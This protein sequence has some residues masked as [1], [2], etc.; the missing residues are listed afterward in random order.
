MALV[1]VLWPRC[2][3][4]WRGVTMLVVAALQPW[5]WFVSCPVQHGIRRGLRRRLQVSQGIVL[6]VGSRPGSLF[7][8]SPRVA[9]GH[10]L[11][12][13]GWGAPPARKVS[14][15]RPLSWILSC[16]RR[17]HMCVLSVCI[18]TVGFVPVATACAVL[19]CWSSVAQGW[20]LTDQGDR[21][22]IGPCEVSV[23]RLLLSEQA[24]STSPCPAQG[25]C[26]RRGHVSSMWPRWEKGSW[27]TLT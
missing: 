26:R 21:C 9:E 23:V 18:R 19:S 6:V 15:S 12:R 16:S 17:D 24:C 25:L 13:R 10:N 1:M 20:R 5:W 14:R 8:L 3:R 27:S 22:H 11:N 2:G 7:A 4:G